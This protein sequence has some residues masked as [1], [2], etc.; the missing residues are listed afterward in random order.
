M[1]KIVV[2]D[3]HAVLREGL[4]ALINAVQDW[5]V[6]AEAK[7]GFEVIQATEQHHPD[8]V[9]LDLSMPRLGGMETLG[10]LKKM[11]NPPVVL[12]LSARDD[13]GVA[14][15][16]IQAGAKGFLPKKSTRN[17]LEFALTSVLK[18]QIY[19]SPSVASAV[20]RH[21]TQSNPLSI[22]SD[23]EREVMKLLCE[24]H[25]NREIA[26]LLHI[27]PRTVDSH[28]AN[29]MKKLGVQSNAELAQM[30]MKAG[31]VE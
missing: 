17:E 5:Q 31:L 28:R 3:D 25:P 19:L 1:I 22:L 9:I 13:E 27:S 10:R 30:A 11:T 20:L 29:I 24:G 2:A 23:R 18:G 15:E 21:D 16:V 4:C 8:A 14:A 6:V 26:S 7:D 12:V